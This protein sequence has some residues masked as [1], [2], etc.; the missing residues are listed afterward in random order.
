L[1][2]LWEEILIF[3]IHELKNLVQFAGLFSYFI[4]HE[5]YKSDHLH[6]SSSSMG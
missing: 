1:G 4:S 2:L 3:S 5:S 6:P